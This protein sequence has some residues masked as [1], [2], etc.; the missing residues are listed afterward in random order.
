ML[1]NQHAYYLQQIGIDIWVPRQASQGCSKVKL[2]VIWDLPEPD[3]VK[4]ARVLLRQML[5]SL[6]ITEQEVCIVETSEQGDDVLMQK[7][8]AVHPQLLFSLGW[9]PGSEQTLE[10]MRGKVHVYQD[11][12]L[13][14]SYHPIHLLRSPEDKKSAYQ[15]L[16]CVQGLLSN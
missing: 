4:K 16:V 13:V 10:Q 6:G 1:N 7:I 9:L 8:K 2:M 11:I 14:I 3:G 5:N 12:P 15:D